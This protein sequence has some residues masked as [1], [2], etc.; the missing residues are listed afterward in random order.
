M[1]LHVTPHQT[2]QDTEAAKRL[3]RIGAWLAALA[4]A[5]GAL[6]A[7]AALLGGLGYRQQWWSLSEGFAGL[8]WAT[9]GALGGAGAA[10]LA[11]GLLA[12]A[13]ARR[14]R[15]MAV[16]AVLLN[17][18]VAV[19]P[20]HLYRQAQGLPKIHD[21]STDTADPPAFVAVL[22]LREGARNPVAYHPDKASQ[23]RRGYPDI[24]PLQL[25][26]APAEAFARA[27]RAAR[28]MGWQIVA[29]A[30][31]A[32]RIEATAATLFFGFKD[33]VVIRIR[34]QGAGSVVDVRSLSRIGGS[35]VGANA[36]RIRSFL[37]RLTAP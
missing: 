19:P 9:F 34:P 5:L 2:R 36:A 29:V 23:Q 21:I 33:D 12:W 31:D 37:A 8:R 15:A 6:S 1:T 26:L 35:D 13:R 24:A 30:P 25:A 27:E 4:L 28:A 20:L 10:L 3:P 11:L 18:L 7:A 16:V 14:G 17:L 32:M 22:P